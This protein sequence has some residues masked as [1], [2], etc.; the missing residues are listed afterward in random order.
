MLASLLLFFPT[1]R[2]T[3][4]PVSSAAL[5]HGTVSLIGTVDVSSLRVFNVQDQ[6]GR[7]VSPLHPQGEQ[8][9]KE[10]KVEASQKGYVPAGEATKTVS[11]GLSLV[12][13]PLTTTVGLVLE[14]A[15][16]GPPNPCACTPPDGAVG[17]GPNH[18][19]EMVNIAGIIYTKAGAVAKA[20]FGLD[21]FFNLPASSLSDPQVSYDAGSGRW[22]ASIIDIPN[23]RVVFAVST[24]NDPTGTFYLYAVTDS[25]HLP[26]QPVTGTND[27]KYV[28]SVNSFNSAGAFVG[29]HYWVLNKSE[30]VAGASTIDFVTNSPDPSMFSLHPGEHLSSSTTFYM[31]TDCTGACVSDPSTT[32]STETVVSFNGVPPGVVTVSSTTFSIATSS[33]PPNAQQPGTGTLLTTDDNRVESVVYEYNT[34][35]AAWTDACIPNGD[36]ATRTCLRL[37]QANVLGSTAAKIQDFD[38]GTMGGYYFYPGITSHYGQLAVSFGTSSSGIFPSA[39]VAGRAANDPVNT[40]Q[41]PV[42][43]KAGSAQDLSTR[44]GDYDGAATDPTPT[45]GSTFWLESEYRKDSTF[46]NWNTIISQVGAFGAP[47]SFDYTVGVTPT[48]GSVV[49]GG[50]TSATATIGLVNGTSQPVTLSTSISPSATGLTARANPTSGIPTFTSA[51][52]ISTTAATPTGSYTIT[53]TGNSG[54]LSRSA[55]YSLK[56]LP[57]PPPDFSISAAPSSLSMSKSGSASATITIASLNGFSGTVS[58]TANPPSG[59]SATFNPVSVTVTS[60]GSGTSML[61]FTGNG[62]GAAG[63]Y[64]ITVTATS[65]SITHTTGISLT[66]TKH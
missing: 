40:L 12:P 38:F 3:P 61:T 16:G 33:V 47:G 18:V 48:S 42:T 37:V 50:S 39:I 6:A 23:S 15:A 49:Q 57:P 2:A 62:K 51:L 46:Q 27:D 8:S 66:L 56:V 26:D 19:F 24:T 1:G 55:T 34:L 13:S 5:T 4:A 53:V 60:G 64:T 59:V 14:G 41:A 52:T 32:T 54:N 63:T 17:A 36:S 29:V 7:I 21:G 9:F 58:L 44:Y 45:A 20:T 31:V 43:V 35:W 25:G 22:F 28:I 11:S 10:A 30:L 65:G